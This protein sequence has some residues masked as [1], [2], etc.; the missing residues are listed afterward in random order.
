LKNLIAV[1]RLTRRARLDRWAKKAPAA[2]SPPGSVTLPATPT[3]LALGGPS[4]P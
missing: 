4:L 2:H 1:G 3:A